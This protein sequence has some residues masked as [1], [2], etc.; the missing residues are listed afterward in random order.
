MLF[1]EIALLQAS[2]RNATIVCAEETE[3]LWVD[4]EE[5]IEKG[6]DTRM[7]QE[8]LFRYHFFR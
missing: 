3:F 5:F 2:R 7:Q 8:F 4:K 1:Q 6:L